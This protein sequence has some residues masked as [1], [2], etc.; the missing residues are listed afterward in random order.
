MKVRIIN[1]TTIFVISL[2]LG[3]C[4]PKPKR[5][6][7]IQEDGLY[8]YIDTIGNVI[9]E[10]QYKYAGDFTEDNTALIISKVNTNVSEDT[11][12]IE[13]GYID[14]SNSL[15]VDT[16]NILRISTHDMKKWGFQYST[17]EFVQ[18]FDN[19]DL[20]FNASFLRELYTSQRMY[21]YMDE[22]AACII[23]KS[24]DGDTT[25]NSSIKNIQTFSV[26]VEPDND[27]I[28]MRKD[29]SFVREG[30]VNKSGDFIW[31]TNHEQSTNSNSHN[32]YLYWISVILVGLFLLSFTALTLLIIIYKISLKREDK[33]ESRNKSIKDGA[34]PN[35]GKDKSHQ[36]Y[37][38]NKEKNKKTAVESCKTLQRIK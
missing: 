3:G 31:E 12:V 38:K 7:R 10:P 11:V 16:A 32:N 2:A 28:Y 36:N 6:I 30:I 5:L 29:T 37:V 25:I 1:A 34:I 22:E 20:D 19:N 17:K 27:F 18:K 23:Y 33:R 8:G 14:S 9:I 26:N 21:P 4:T 13:Y 15:V 24:I 35:T